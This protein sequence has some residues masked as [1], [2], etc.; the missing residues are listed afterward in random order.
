MKRARTGQ[1]QKPN[2]SRRLAVAARKLIS[3]ALHRRAAIALPG[4]LL[5]AQRCDL[6]IAPRFD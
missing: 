1:N 3:A 2:L 4:R 5:S 6:M